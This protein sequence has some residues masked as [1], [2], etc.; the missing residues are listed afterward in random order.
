MRQDQILHHIE[1]TLSK[2][3]A[4]M[5]TFRFIKNILHCELMGLVNFTN[6]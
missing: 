2:L 3:K 6:L 5:I 4:S 1:S